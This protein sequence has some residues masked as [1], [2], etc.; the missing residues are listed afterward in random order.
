MNSASQPDQALEC[1]SPNLERA[2][3]TDLRSSVGQPDFWWSSA[4]MTFVS[5]YRRSYLG[6]FWAIIPPAIYIFAIGGFIGTLMGGAVRDVFAHVAVGFVI[7]R[8]FSGVAIAASSAL[9]ANASFI[10]DGRTRLTDYV[11]RTLS[12]E[13]LY[14]LA[15]APLV[16]LAMYLDGSVSLQGLAS[17]VLS[18]PLLA[19]NLFLLAVSAAML[20]VRYP[21]LSDVLGSVFMFAFLITPIVWFPN[22]VEVGGFHWWSMQLN[23]LYHLIEVCRAPLLGEPLDPLSPA[24]VLGLTVLAGVVAWLSYR[25]FAARAPQWL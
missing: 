10:L 18:V 13:G 25:V 23:P 2:L 20:G 22:Q 16:L 15:A 7:F 8:A 12:I 6:L 9:V 1:Y 4:W 5:K 19:L 14:V 24:I 21:D 11:L 17:L 3:W